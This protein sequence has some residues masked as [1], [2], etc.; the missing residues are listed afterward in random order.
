MYA[1]LQLPVHCGSLRYILLVKVRWEVPELPDRKLNL[2][3]RGP[4]L[5]LEP[6]CVSPEVLPSVCQ[7]LPSERA[8]ELALSGS[9]NAFGPRRD[10]RTPKLSFTSVL[11]P[12]LL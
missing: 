3:V 1:Y 4:A 9:P 5:N 7:V 11:P 6:P 8:C 10:S 2:K 12:V